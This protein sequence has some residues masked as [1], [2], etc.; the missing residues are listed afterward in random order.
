MSLTLITKLPLHQ[1]WSIADWVVTIQVLL[2]DSGAEELLF[3]GT[4]H[5]FACGVSDAQASNLVKESGSRDPE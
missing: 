5:V 3:P 1:F 2:G 4:L